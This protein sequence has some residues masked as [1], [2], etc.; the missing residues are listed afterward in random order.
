[1]VSKYSCSN[2]HCPDVGFRLIN[3]QADPHLVC[4][5]DLADLV[6]DPC[7]GSSCWSLICPKGERIRFLSKMQPTIQRV[8]KKS[9]VQ[10][11]G[12]E[13]TLKTMLGWSRFP[14]NSQTAIE[15]KSW[16]V[17]H[18]QGNRHFKIDTLHRC[19][20]TAHCGVTMGAEPTFRQM[21][22]NP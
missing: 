22:N 2:N 17:H 1:M 5:R 9:A 14:V 16:T 6:S 19:S 3:F 7:L 11:K 4:H 13:T 20:V 21:H 8:L 15:A 12:S 18:C 10:G